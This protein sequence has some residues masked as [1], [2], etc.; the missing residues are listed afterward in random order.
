[1]AEKKG[2]YAGML[3]KEKPTQ[4]AKNSTSAAQDKATVPTKKETKK[5]TK[6]DA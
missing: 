4:V 1:V 5:S 3:I 2:S 6:Q